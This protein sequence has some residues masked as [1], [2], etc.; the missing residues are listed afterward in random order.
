MMM[1]YTLTS[2]LSLEG[3]ESKRAPRDA[4]GAESISGLERG[5][6]C[7]LIR[8]GFDEHVETRRFKCHARFW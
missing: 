3:K 6:S 5:Y 7:V 4:Q 1:D 8:K 2:S